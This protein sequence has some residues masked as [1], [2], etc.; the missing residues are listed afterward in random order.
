M[1]RNVLHIITGLHDGG[2][3]AVL[4]RLCTYDTSTTH[5]VV[6][7]TGRGKYAPLLEERGIRV[8]CLGMPPGLVT[9]GALWRL[10]RLLRRE[11]PGLVQTWM[12]HADLIGGI[13]ARLAGVRKVFWNIRNS[14]LDPQHS[15]RA[16]ILVAKACALVSRWVPTGISCC[17]QKAYEVHRDLGYVTGKMTLIPNGYDVGR[18]AEDGNARQAVRREF[19]LPDDGILIG[20]VARFDPQKDHDNLLKALLII[21]DRGLRFRCVLVGRGLEPS[22]QQLVGRI[23]SLSLQDIVMLAGPRM[24]IPSVMNALD[25]H[26]LSSAYGEAFPNVVA[27]AMAC[28]TPVVVTDVGDAA[29]IAGETGWVVPPRDPSALADAL[30]EALT[31]PTPERLERG[32]Q[33]R[34]RIVSLFS[35]DTMVA[36]YHSL[37][38]SR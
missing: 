13:V 27:E 2:A 16:T 31:L 8:T 38:N 17:A 30:Q 22:N 5:H 32:R 26:V 6:S 1:K 7:L 36:A 23:S 34:E 20:M 12:Y 19:R 35:M 24:D 25:L 3:E 29:A 18:L 15:T 4:Y 33:A 10:W 21:R 9:P 37:W 14:N 11:R 28:G